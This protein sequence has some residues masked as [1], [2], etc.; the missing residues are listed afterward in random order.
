MDAHNMFV[1]VSVRAVINCPLPLLM[2]CLYTIMLQCLLL[3]CRIALFSARTLIL[4]N[5]LC[6]LTAPFSRGEVRC[7]FLSV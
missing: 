5:T 3:F 4:V 7:L 6:R 1:D 2:V